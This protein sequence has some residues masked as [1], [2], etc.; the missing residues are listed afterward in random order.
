MVDFFIADGLVMVPFMACNIILMLACFRIGCLVY[1]S[2]SPAQNV[3]S[4]FLYFYF[5]IVVVGQLLGCVG[6]LTPCMFLVLNG[7]IGSLLLYISINA[8]VKHNCLWQGVM[9]KYNNVEVVLWG[10]WFVFIL[11]YIVSKTMFWY[12]SEWDSLVYH[13]PYVDQWYRGESLYARDCVIW[14]NPGNNELIAFWMVGPFSGDF[15]FGL[16]NFPAA[17]LCVCGSIQIFKAL[18]LPVSMCHIC[19]LG[20]SANFIYFFQL[21]TSMNDMAVGAFFL[22]GAGY[23][24]RRLKSRR[25]V[26][27][28]HVFMA[29]G[30]LCG[31]KYYAIGYAFVLLVSLF[32]EEVM[33]GGLYNR[34]KYRMLLCFAVFASGCIFWY[35]R[36]YLITGHPFF[37][38]GAGERGDSVTDY[39]P[40][41][42]SSTFVGNGSSQIYA[43]FL[44]DVGNLSGPLQYMSILCL[45][46]MVVGLI[47]L[48]NL[49][50]TDVPKRAIRVLF[51]LWIGSLAV[52][53]VTPFAVESIPGTLNQLILGLCPVRYGYCF[54]AMC[55]VVWCFVLNRV[56]VEYVQKM[57]RKYGG[58]YSV[59]VIDWLWCLAWCCGVGYQLYV[60]LRKSGD[61]SLLDV[62]CSIFIFVSLINCYAV[63]LLFDKSVGL[64]R[65]VFAG[66]VF[67]ACFGA[68]TISN[69][70]HGGFAYYYDNWYTYGMIDYINN[71]ITKEDGICILDE[72]V[73]PYFGSFRDRNIIQVAPSK[74]VS[75]WLMAVESY[76]IKYL[77][78]RIGD[79]KHYNNWNHIY[80]YVKTDE[81]YR[82]K[83]SFR[84][85]LVLF[86]ID[87]FVI[88]E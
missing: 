63:W 75:S 79:E 22:V 87:D 54:I 33:I 3:G 52:F 62:L 77:L 19:A 14:S 24:M 51:L 65:C 2:E 8:P 34:S 25:F 31:I 35:I 9:D 86:E 32:L 15:F 60:V 88:G 82:V 58:E 5:C 39:Y 10:F 48:Y 21:K 61:I 27:L 66:T 36:N 42:W 30:I 59:D 64:L 7:L 44:T 26:D 78:I 56:F 43:L 57:A 68:V 72:R 80:D 13:M 18:G 23:L 16:N 73:Y 71:N 29:S 76:K 53:S 12:P 37:P 6:M 38:L 47:L 20:V 83:C 70:W 84:G 45:P 85:E 67:I 40:E 49:E 1:N 81:K 11:Y 69:G 4:A 74:S 28:V 46:C 41:I 17:I 55:V 50:K